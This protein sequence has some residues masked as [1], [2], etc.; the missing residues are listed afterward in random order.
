MIIKYNIFEGRESS[1]D[2]Y[3]IN[4]RCKIG[5]HYTED[6]DNKYITTKYKPEFKDEL[7]KIFNNKPVT[8]YCKQCKKTHD[9][10][11]KYITYLIGRS[12][13]YKVYQD[14]NIELELPSFLFWTSDNTIEDKKCIYH[15]PD[16]NK[17][18]KVWKPNS[19]KAEEIEMKENA[20]KYNL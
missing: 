5:N 14:N 2:S 19:I 4:L 1:F 11:N 9:I 15:E 13:M 12:H 3:Q 16:L 10:Y 8:F 20:K 7:E 6:I 17:V 18:V